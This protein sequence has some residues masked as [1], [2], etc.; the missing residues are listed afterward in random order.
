MASSVAMKK[1]W[2]HRKDSDVWSYIARKTEPGENGCINW[3]KGSKHHG[4]GFFQYNYVT[5]GAH[6]R[7]YEAHQGPVP[8]HLV[9]R[10]TCDNRR[11]VNI[12]HLE[13]GTRKDNRQ[14]FMKR[15]PRAKDLMKAAWQRGAVGVKNFWDSMTA[16]E[17]HSFAKRRSDVQNAKGKRPSAL[18]RKHSAETRA[19]MRASQ[20]AR[21]KRKRDARAGT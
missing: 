12:D 17:R 6:R 20:T 19:K 4:Y 7:V 18:G 3:K 5:G 14:D 9:V 11:C 1:G 13:V 10:H 8:D 15:H 21:H 2:L 16:E